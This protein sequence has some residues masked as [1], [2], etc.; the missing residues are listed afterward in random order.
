M[1]EKEIK[2]DELNFHQ[3]RRALKDAGIKFKPTDKTDAL[4]SM[5]RSGETIHKPKPQ[6]RA[7]QLSDYKHENTSMAALPDEI[8]PRLENLKAKG[9]NWEIVK[10]TCSII[11]TYRAPN[12]FEFRSTTTLDQSANNIYVAA[13]D[14]LPGSRPIEEGNPN[15]T[16]KPLRDVV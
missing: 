7:P 1:T 16:G 14:T 10:D 12:G 2:I 4:R 15:V 11:F 5:L 3:L 13:R 8:M 9:L 6:P